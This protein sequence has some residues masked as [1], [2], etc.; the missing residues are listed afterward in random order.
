MFRDWRRLYQ[1]AFVERSQNQLP[2]RITEARQAV[3]ERVLAL[4]QEGADCAAEL[5]LLIQAAGVLNR[6]E[7]LTCSQLV[8]DTD[9][10]PVLDGS[11][12][13]Y[14]EAD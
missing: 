3:A 5:E 9:I 4:L 6:L 8:A 14:V 13:S 12:P 11:T 7:I 2:G 1:A 10:P